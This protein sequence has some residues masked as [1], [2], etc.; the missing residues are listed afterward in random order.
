ME[1]QDR[2]REYLKR[3]TADLHQARR[4]LRK[5]ES[6]MQEP[7][8]IVGMACRYPGGVTS[9]AALWQLVS[10]EQ[11]AIAEFPAGRGW[12][13]GQ[14][15]DPDPE[16]PGKTYTRYGGFL[17]DAD[18]FDAEFFGISPREALAI[19]PQQRLLLLETAWEALERAGIG[20][21]ALRGTSGGV[22]VGVIGQ[23]YASLS[24]QG[25]EDIDGYLLTGTTTSV[26][27]G[28]IAYTLGLEGPAVT[29]DTACSS[30]LVAIHL[31]VHALRNGECSLALAGGATVM[32]TPGMFLEFSRQRGLAP[33]G[34]CKSFAAAADGTAWAEGA[35]ML[36]LERLSEAQ[37]LGHRVLAVVPGSAV[38]QDGASNGLTAPNGPAQ[39]R[40]IRQALANARLSPSD[41]D[42]VEAHGTG[43][44]LGDPIEAQALIATYGQDRPAE[45]PLW[46]GSL[47]SNIGHAQ[48]AAGVGGGIKMVQALQHGMLPRTLHLDSPTPHV[49][50]DAGAVALLAQAQPWPETG[51][52]RRA[53]V[54][55]FGISGTNAHLILE[56]A[57]AAEDEPAQQPDE[58][59]VPPAVPWL[60]SAR[61][62]PALREQAARL[63]AHLQDS[64]DMRPVDVACTLAGG[65][66]HLEQRAVVLGGDRD[67][68]LSGVRSL[69]AGSADPGVVRGQVGRGKLA[70][71]FT[72]QGCQYPGMGRELYAAFP[73][74]A[75]AFDQ[76]CQQ[77]DP[78]LDQ[79]LQQVVFAEPGTELA[80]LLDQT[81]YTQPALFAL[82][83]ALWQLLTSLGVRADFVAGHSVGQISAAHA[84]GVLSLADAAN[85]IAVRARLMQSAPAG[86]A[87]IAIQATEAEI[88]PF[89][90]G[91]SDRVGIAAVNTPTSTVISGDPQTVTG[92]A[93]YWAGQG[94]RTRALTVSHAFH[95][96][97][98][99]PVLE[100]FTAAIAGLDFRSPTIPVICNRTGQLATAE[101]LADPGYWAEH[102]RHPVRFA[103]TI[104][105]LHT[106]GTTTY[107]ELGPDTTLTTL[108]TLAAAT[109]PD[110]TTDTDTA[111]GTT[112]GDA[113]LLTAALRPGHPEPATTLTAL[114]H[115]HTHGHPTTWTSL[116]PGGH[117]TELPTY[118]FQRRSYWLDNASASGDPATFGLATA[119]HALLGA[120]AELPDGEGHLFVGR[121]SV[122]THPWIAEHAIHNT[123]IVPGAAFVGLLSHAGEHVGCNQIEEL[124]HHV[125][126]AVPEEGA[127][128]LRLSVA[129]PDEAGRRAFTV[130]SRPENAPP[131]TPWTQHATGTLANTPAQ[132]PA[133]LTTWPPTEAATPVDVDDLYER[134]ATAGFGYGPYF[135][136]LQRAWRDGDTI[137]AEV[138][139]PD[140]GDP[141][142]YGIHPGLLDSA[143]HPIAVGTAA[144]PGDPEAAQVRVPF[145]WGGVSLHSAGARQLR[146]RLGITGPDTLSL[147]I[148]DQAGTPVASIG[149][150]LT[151]PVSPAQLAAGIGSG[152]QVLYR[153]EWAPLAVPE[154][155]AA[156]GATDAAGWV[157][158]GDPIAEV[159]GA[160]YPDLAALAQAVEAGSAAVPPVILTRPRT[161]DAGIDPAGSDPVAATHAA[162]ADMLDLAQAFLADARFEQSRLVVLTRAAQAVTD[163]AP[164]TD[165][166]AAAVWGLIRTA[167]SEN[168]DRFTLIDLDHNHRSDPD[169]HADP[170]REVPTAVSAALAA[171]EPQL[172]VRGGAVHVPRLTRTTPATNQPATRP[173]DPDGT[174]LI[175]GGTGN[176]GAA[177]ARH[178]ITTHQ[179]RHLVL[180]SRRGPDADN[181]AT[182]HQE[183]TDLGGSITL[184]ACDV[185]D[186]RQVAALLEGMPAERP[187]TAVFH[188]AG[189]LHDATLA[190]LS[191]P[192]LEAV[193]RPKVDAAWQLHEQ[194][195]QLD[196][197]AFVLFSSIAGVLGNPG[198]GNYAAANTFLD[199]LAAHRHAAGLPA[200]SLA[201]GPWTTGMAA[202][203]STADHTRITRTGITPLTTTQALTLLDTAL[204]R[205]HP[206]LVPTTLDTTQLRSNAAAGDV[207]PLLRSL[208]RATP[209][210]VRRP[211]ATH[212]ALAEQLA[213]QPEAEQQRILLNLVRTHVAAV[214]GH[215]TPDA[216]GP[217]QAFQEL[218]FDSLTGVELRTRLSTATGMRLPATLVFD[219]PTPAALASY[220][221]RQ[222]GASQTPAA[223]RPAVRA[224]VADGEPIAIVA[225]GCRFPGGSDTPERL[226]RM[227]E[228]GVDAVGEFPA[229]RGWNIEELYDPD[230]DASGKTYARHGG[231]VYDADRFDAEFFGISPREALAIEPQQ[232]LLLETAWE[233]LEGIGVDPASL[234]GSATGVFAGV[235]AQE[236]VSLCHTGPEGIEGYLLTGNTTSVASGR[237]AYTWA[238]RGR[239]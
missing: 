103:E 206:T 6:Q 189:V 158:V 231:F 149:N 193:L 99:D 71:L 63:A 41:V 143:L 190:T 29:V 226:W 13:V 185:T 194:T 157:V 69:A 230:P 51:R 53:A 34:R 172:A 91:L 165:L 225:M 224:T 57:P 55:S 134:L 146:V 131:Q 130:H 173:L 215:D 182:L 109:L 186:A 229:G 113:P 163:A 2:L 85:L 120:A 108:T 238:W 22:F 66:S 77:L 19:E 221:Q 7:I 180:V 67:S 170:D 216:V 90:D 72:G 209:R 92:I 59:V 73:V 98:M 44:K 68:L 195:R 79:P 81:R 200:M 115:L 93:E 84:A 160:R 70:V 187:L 239:R 20:P 145:S 148:A 178:L 33:D 32:A 83:V 82:E 88:L 159:P 235:S 46:L 114:A 56:Q 171:A 100:E 121:I 110:T 42:A 78:H 14:L 139:L 208:I 39:E 184:A 140:G 161:G 153:V 201:W 128:Q 21:G 94:R 223:R 102:I 129:A 116:H 152:G 80:V 191:G 197:A 18:R 132:P 126:L 138:A 9:P 75:A 95:S 202:T 49:D 105:T 3:V 151:R 183:L 52:P 168:P 236:Y 133:E 219:Y 162:T 142:S 174:V 45:Q 74:F 210:H 198:Q 156:G 154:R 35:G 65:R 220:L 43:T 234:R 147:T 25:E 164:V 36:V 97:H 232:R 15:Y 207:N 12:D 137:Y 181:A 135:L 31:A 141:G 177:V 111:A 119:S 237:I 8:A 127:L 30:S 144:D 23:E 10:D 136:G 4:Q 48:A 155:A 192:Q 40:V 213:G 61:T 58:V 5:V 125:F 179:V 87:M 11:D 106:H 175:T 76:A 17:Y 24:R 50:W 118:P 107:L 64:P 54:S 60:L 96:P 227:V 222:A 62:E 104:T 117:P 1:H 212:S 124:T 203:L 28:R 166:P 167:Q 86:G 228:G 122:K 112:T 188:T 38:N 26:A 211:A 199:A 214:L 205:P 47:K 16:T 196:L 233:A 218:G 37:R 169:D 204:T 89:L 27:S 101:Q 123:L 176:L 150:L 217:T